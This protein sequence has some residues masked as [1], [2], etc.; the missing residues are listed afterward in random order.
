MIDTGFD[1]DIALPV[2]EIHALGLPPAGYVEAVLGDGSEVELTMY[3]ATLRWNN[4]HRQAQVL[5]TAGAALVGTKL[6]Q[7]FELQ[8]HFVN[9]GDVLI[10]PLDPAA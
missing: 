7:S 5:E 6:L 10:K 4:E 2:S 9:D 3:A 8:I 1:G